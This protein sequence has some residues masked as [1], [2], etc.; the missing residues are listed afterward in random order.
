MAT[1]TT[2]TATQIVAEKRLYEIRTPARP[3]RVRLS[4]ARTVRAQWPTI[5]P[6]AILYWR[7]NP[8]D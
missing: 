5:G 3:Q 2:R 4:H 1:E 6:G 7:V 8:L